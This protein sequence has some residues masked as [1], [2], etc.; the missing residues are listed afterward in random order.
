[1][2]PLSL[3]ALFALGFF[4]LS[5]AC[6][7]P[8]LCERKA[9]FL[10][11]RCSGGSVT[12]TPDPYCENRVKNCNPAQLAQFKGYVSCLESAGVCSLEVMN[13]CRQKYPGGVNLTCPGA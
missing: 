9:K 7:G 13:Q 10:N 4:T 8:S 3:T 6:A 1:M 2:K 11:T 12:A 5:T